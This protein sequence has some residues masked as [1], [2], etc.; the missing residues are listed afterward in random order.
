MLVGM[1]SCAC[2]DVQLCLWGF[3]AVLVRM[4]SCAWGCAAV[5]VG[6]CSRAYGPVWGCAAVLVD[7]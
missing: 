5:L 2:G 6:M 1:C 3:A 7:Q 4:C